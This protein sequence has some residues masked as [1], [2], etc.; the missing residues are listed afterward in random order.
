MYICLDVKLIDLYLRPIDLIHVSA[1]FLLV[2]IG[3]NVCVKQCS[4][5]K[6]V[7]NKQAA[8]SNHIYMPN[9]DTG[10]LMF[11]VEC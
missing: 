6:R 1:K 9:D 2:D 11:I 8:I 5:D 7:T 10:L 3:E 4:I